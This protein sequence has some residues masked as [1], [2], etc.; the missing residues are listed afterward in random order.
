MAWKVIPFLFH[1]S[2]RLYSGVTEVFDLTA[3]FE[4]EDVQ[5]LQ[6]NFENYRNVTQALVS[7]LVEKG[8]NTGPNLLTD[9]LYLKW[10]NAQTEVGGVCSRRSTGADICK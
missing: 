4:D 8:G 7:R 3:Y 10:Q 9:E 1:C 2:S 6:I 5:R